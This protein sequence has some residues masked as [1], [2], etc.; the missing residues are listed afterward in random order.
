MHGRS[1]GIGSVCASSSTMTLPAKLCSLRHRE[2][3]AANR[4]SKNCTAVVTTI[5]TSQF[6]AARRNFA[7]PSGPSPSSRRA[8]AARSQSKLAWCS[9]TSSLVFSASRNTWAVCSMIEVK[10]IT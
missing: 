4:L 2:G 8:S 5:G 10:G 7:K 1:S 6:S 3:R 9:R